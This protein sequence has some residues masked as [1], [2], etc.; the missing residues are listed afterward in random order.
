[1]RI[2]I[3]NVHFY[4]NL[5][6]EKKCQVKSCEDGKVPIAGKVWSKGTQG[7]LNVRTKDPEM[8]PIRTTSKW[9]TETLW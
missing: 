6:L 7:S 3:W 5:V 1:M 8:C 9:E 2:Y 4:V